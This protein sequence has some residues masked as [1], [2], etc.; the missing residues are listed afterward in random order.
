MAAVS[1]LFSRLLHVGESDNL[2]AM[3]SPPYEPVPVV[4]GTPQPYLQDQPAWPPTPQ[5]K[6][7]RKPPW[8]IWLVVAA[9]FVAGCVLGVTAGIG[10][11]NDKQNTAG[12]QAATTQPPPQPTGNPVAAGTT[13]A[14][15]PTTHTTTTKPPPPAP[16]IED[17]TWTVGT[18]MPAGKYRTT[19]PVDSQCYW[20]IYKSG[21]NKADII[22]N[23]IPGGGRPTVTVKVGE[24]FESSDCGT[25]Q[26]IG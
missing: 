17:G 19:A 9:A 8:W 18:D 5:V 6:V 23:D 3:T 13:P 21:T 11:A 2:S 14:P 4:P 25:W 15:A 1:R 12:Q 16:T 22:A 7:V 26:K 20:G 24:D 10:G